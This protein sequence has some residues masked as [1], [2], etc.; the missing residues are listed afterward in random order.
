MIFVHVHGLV[1]SGRKFT[2]KDTVDPRTGGHQGENVSF[3]EGCVLEKYGFT[4]RYIDGKVHL[5]DPT[6]EPA[7][8]GLSPLKD[9]SESDGTD[10]GI[11]PLALTHDKNVIDNAIVILLLQ[12]QVA[13][14]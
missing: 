6:V 5:V 9:D 3:R 10:D 13:T 11:F 12:S 2:P 1:V 4:K 7:L 8:Q 14:K